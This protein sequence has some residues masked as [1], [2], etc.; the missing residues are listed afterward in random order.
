MALALRVTWLHFVDPSP[1]DGRLDDAAVY[2]RLAMSIKNGDG[3]QWEDGFSGPPGGPFKVV[4]TAYW[5][6]GYPA[7]LAGVYLVTDASVPGGE[8]AQRV[9]GRGDM[10]ARVRRRREVFDRRVGL[11]GAGDAGALPEPGLPANAADDGDA[12]DLPDNAVAG[13]DA[14]ADAPNADDRRESKVAVGVKALPVA[15]LG[16]VFGAAS[17]VRGEM[18]AFPLVLVAVWAIAIRFG[19][20][21]G[22][23]RGR[24]RRRDAGWRC[25]R[26]RCGTGRS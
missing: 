7:M 4:P 9:S 11:V 25:R 16:L 2:H 18:L 19:A 13:A 24:R 8:A 21:G 5:S 20:A 12:V 3:F 26:G 1:T 22:D 23:L 17:L 6:V 15:V 14:R 10:P